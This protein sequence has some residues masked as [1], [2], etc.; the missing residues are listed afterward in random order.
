QTNTWRHSR[1]HAGG[2]ALL[3]AGY[4]LVDLVHYLCGPFDTVSATLWSNERLD[5]GQEIDDRAWLTGRAEHCWV[6]LDIW[7]QGFLCEDQQS[8]QK[9]E[10][11]ELIT[12]CGLV[13]ANRDGVWHCGQQV[14]CEDR[15]WQ[16]AMISQLDQFARQ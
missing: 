6:M 11:L 5:D 9:S 16:R 4:H 15:S 7:V 2:G 3:D 13:I 1:I 8:Y 12:D 10:S 14:F